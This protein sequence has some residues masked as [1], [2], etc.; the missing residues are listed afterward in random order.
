MRFPERVASMKSG[1]RLL[2]LSSLML[3]IL[4]MVTIDTIV[5]SAQSKSSEFMIRMF[6][7][8]VT[9]SRVSM[10]REDLGLIELGTRELVLTKFV[11]S[12]SGVGSYVEIVDRYALTNQIVALSKSSRYDPNYVAILESN[13]ELLILKKVSGGFVPTRI[14]LHGIPMVGGKV[15]VSEDGFFAVGFGNVLRIGRFGENGWCEFGL[16]VGNATKSSVEGIS[17]VDFAMATTRSSKPLAIAPYLALSYVKEVS[18]DPKMMILVIAKAMI[19][20]RSVE[21]AI[22]VLKYDNVTLTSVTTSE[23]TAAIPVPY[24]ATNITVEAYYVNETL[25]GTTF[26]GVKKLLGP[27]KPGEIRYVEVQLARYPIAVPTVKQFA[28]ISIAKIVSLTGCSKSFEN[29]LFSEAIATV[30]PLSVKIHLFIVDGSRAVLFVSYRDKMPTGA[31]FYKLEVQTIDLSKH[32]IVWRA[33][34]R[35]WS[36]VEMV[37]V[38]E[39]LELVAVVT[40]GNN[41][42]VF[43]NVDGYRFELIESLVLPSKPTSVILVGG[44]GGKGDTYVLAAGLENG[45]VVLYAYRDYFKSFESVGRRTRY[46][47]LLCRGRAYVD[48]LPKLSA[49]IASCGSAVYYAP[50]MGTYLDKL[51]TEDLSKY[52]ARNL[53]VKVINATGFGIPANVSIRGSP[54]LVLWAR[55]G[56]VVIK[57][58]AFGTHSVMIVPA[59]PSYPW[60]AMNVSIG[61]ER[62][63]LKLRVIDPETNKSMVVNY[64]SIVCTDGRKEALILSRNRS[65]EL[66]FVEGE[67]CSV[68]IS[69][70]PSY[71][72]FHGEVFVLKPYD[73]VK[74]NVSM[75]RTFTVLL[76]LPRR[77]YAD[78]VALCLYTEDGLPIENAVVQMKNVQ[79]N[80]SI[81]ANYNAS[82]Q[83]YEVRNIP[84]GVYMVT[85]SNLSEV[86]QELPP[87]TISVNASDLTFTKIVPY[88]PMSLKIR[89][90]TPPIV[91]LIVSVGN[92]SK[93]VKR[94]T[95]EVEFHG[96]KP[97]RYVVRI[98][99]LPTLES[100]GTTK[101]C[102]YRNV[103]RVVILRKPMELE[104]SLIPI[105]KRVKIAIVDI[106]TNRGPID[107]LNV[108]IDGKLVETLKAQP[109]A[110]AIYLEGYLPKGRIVNLTIVSL[111]KIYA[112]FKELLNVDKIGDTVVVKLRRV[113][114]PI[115]INTVSS[116][117]E[118]LSGVTIDANCNGRE[119]TVTSVDGVAQLYVPSYVSCILVAK[120]AGYSSARASVSITNAP[121]TLTMVLRPH[122][123]TLVFKYITLIVAVAIVGA[124]A[125]ILVYLRKKIIEKVYVSTEELL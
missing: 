91:D 9:V 120:M 92:A 56:S 117:G 82:S 27:F 60:I 76:E 7:M 100:F 12:K 32:R 38:S 16:R 106:L 24:N 68:N 89:F 74:L 15:Y 34:Y 33:W 122:I 110:K 6:P 78:R 69:L 107:K 51:Y 96:L 104:I 85:V 20:N 37:S 52:L 31:T 5:V 98:Q 108:Y 70:A 41:V 84:F 101:V 49:M 115:T 44:A 36:P 103:T 14:K 83:C 64:V 93:Y 50:F 2:A 111:G 1:V 19:G 77:K 102:Y 58:I 94:G 22:I 72:V 4:S 116:L 48:A 53:V 55:N 86:L 3:L 79:T 28:Y 88:K 35:L 65:V 71:V 26:Y 99:A 57:N 114:V 39:D 54:E 81:H 73:A 59:M 13:G 43:R 90:R 121:V 21:G 10:L 40:S 109:N 11:A 45:Y 124:I 30:D 8:G 46:G 63:R 87:I 62:A 25:G 95:K 75:S 42:Y 105:Y 66:D 119:I 17:V 23:G 61:I 67:Q 125:G 112:T 97:G 123:L 113:L 18:W 29:P 118:K 80:L 47:L